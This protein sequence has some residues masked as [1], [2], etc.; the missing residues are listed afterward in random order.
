[1][2]TSLPITTDDLIRTAVERYGARWNIEVFFK[3]LKSG[4]RIEERQFECLDRE[5]NAIAVYL[6]IAWRVTALCRLG[7]VC[8]DLCC[9]VMFEPSE[10]QAVHLIVEKQPLP[11]TPPPLS[12]MIR[13]VASLGGYVQK[14]PPNPAPKPCGSACYECTTSPTP[15]IPSPPRSD[16][17]ILV[18]YDE[19]FAGG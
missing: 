19:G 9:E 1:M 12:T 16:K 15:T 4:C 6:I 3:T 18:W 11:K 10:W 5:L 17:K 2:L 13:M 7:R 14:I 8:P